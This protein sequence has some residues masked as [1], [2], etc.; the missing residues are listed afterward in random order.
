MIDCVSGCFWSNFVIYFLKF[1]FAGSC[2][3]L[4]I[5]NIEIIH[6]SSILKINMI[7]KLALTIQHFFADRFLQ[8]LPETINK[9]NS[10]Y[11]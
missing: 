7:S 9:L 3:C 4:I 5:L 11:L 8:I 6:M 10:N 2:H 1:Q